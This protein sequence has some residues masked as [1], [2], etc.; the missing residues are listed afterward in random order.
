MIKLE[1]I[2]LLFLKFLFILFL[3]L[4][5][6]FNDYDNDDDKFNISDNYKSYI[7]FKIVFV[8]YKCVLYF[9]YNSFKK[10]KNVI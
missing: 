10:K 5:L 4:F 8:K 9:Y 2:S 6:C 3:F 1:K 7:D